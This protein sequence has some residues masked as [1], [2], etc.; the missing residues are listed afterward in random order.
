VEEPIDT[1]GWEVILPSDK[2]AEPEDSK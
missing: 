2:V 1:T